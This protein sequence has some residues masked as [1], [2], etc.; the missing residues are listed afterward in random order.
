MFRAND[1]LYYCNEENNRIETCQ[2]KKIID[3]DSIYLFSLSSSPGLNADS[4]S[5][6]L[7]TV[8]G[9]NVGF[10]SVGGGFNKFTVS[11]ATEISAEP[12]AGILEESIASSPD[13]VSVVA[14]ILNSSPRFLLH[15]HLLLSP[16]QFA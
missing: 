11:G 15:F 13:G 6:F 5:R 7:T 12:H 10:M 14:I 4:E 16:R 3:K 8:V 2:Y 1:V 9:F